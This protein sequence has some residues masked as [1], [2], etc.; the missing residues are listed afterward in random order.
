[1]LTMRQGQVDAFSREIRKAFGKRQVV[2]LRTVF[3]KETRQLDDDS[4][5]QRIEKTVERAEHYDVVNEQDLEL[6]LDCTFMMAPDF[7]ASSN[8]AWA[9]QILNRPVLTGTEKMSLIHDRM[10]FS[11]Y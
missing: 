11:G 7:D 2:R 4:L 1:M 6:F 3:P 5:L 8:S 9:G 10:L